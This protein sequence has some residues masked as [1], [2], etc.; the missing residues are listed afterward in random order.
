MS[1]RVL[2]T[3]SVHTVC[4]EL[5][6]AAGMEAVD[7]SKWDDERITEECDAF[8]AWIVRSGTTITADWIEKASRLKVVGRAGVGVDNVNLKAATKRGILVLN[9][10]AGNT[11]STAEHTMALMMSVMRN[12]PAAV[13][14]MKEGAWKRKAFMGAELFGK[15][16][17]VVGLGKI[18]KEV[19]SRAAA[20]GMDIIGSD[21][22]M[23]SEA[24]DRIGIELVAVDAIFER[25][26]IITFH[27]P[28]V[29]STRD[30]INDDTLARC[31]H[32]VVI[33]IVHAE[34]SSMKHRYFVG[35]NPVRSVVLVWMC[36][37][38]SRHRSLSEP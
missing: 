36:I 32:G 6:E 11:L 13:A 25:A 30:L 15:T 14:S 24:A 35:L 37:P 38:V 10:P 21:P 16:L 1:Y 2:L 7:A 12:V 8:D 20:F 22:M 18:G 5:L 9:A 23:T 27:T 29:A 19:A 34:E 17:G 3:D 31:K 28:L 33:P 4:Y 26:D